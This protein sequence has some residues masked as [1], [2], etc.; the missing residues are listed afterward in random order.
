MNF[1]VFIRASVV[2][3]FRIP[4][5]YNGA[6]ALR[7]SQLTLIGF[8]RLLDKLAGQAKGAKPG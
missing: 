4:L 2:I 3:P 7:N 1:N 6:S 5:F 8:L